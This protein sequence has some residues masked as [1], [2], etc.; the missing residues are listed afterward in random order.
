MNVNYS[1]SKPGKPHEIIL[2]STEL[3]SGN[4]LITAKMIDKNGQLC[5]DYN[6]R[7]YFSSDGDGHLLVNYGTPTKSQLIEMA[8]GKASIEF[9][10]VPGGNTVIEARNQDFKGSYLKLEGN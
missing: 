3:N 8:N 4:I 5:T 2:S 10:P 1:Y 7:V 6:K 9:V